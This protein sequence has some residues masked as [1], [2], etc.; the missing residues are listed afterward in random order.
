VRHDWIDAPQKM[1]RRNPL[2]KVE[3]IK[4]LALIAGLLPHHGRI[5]PP[6]TS[7]KKRNQCSQISARTFSTASVVS[8][9][10][11]RATTHDQISSF[12]QKPFLRRAASMSR[13]L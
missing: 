7:R 13:Y 9:N 11:N 6:D 5:T 1:A 4:Q 2:F 12:Y 10:S 3:Q 8:R